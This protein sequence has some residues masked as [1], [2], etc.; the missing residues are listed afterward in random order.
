MAITNGSIIRM[1]SVWQ[2]NNSDE[3]ANVWH[4]GVSSVAS[5]VALLYDDIEEYLVYLYGTVAGFIVDDL[6]H[7][8]VEVFNQSAG[9]PEPW[10]G[11][12]GDLDGTDA[13]S[14]LPAGVAALVYAR[15]FVSRVIGKKYMPTASE[16]ELVNGQFSGAYQTALL[17][18]A[19]R[20]AGNFTASNGTV[21]TP[22][23]WRV[24][25]GS[26]V[27]IMSTHV[28]VNPAYQRRRKLGRG[29]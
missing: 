20:W 28:T 11:A 22:R 3:Q 10:I 26:D 9:T 1:A 5:T 15:T 18:L 7:N 14:P 12:I 24:S 6:T 23:I 19:T 16:N 21:F 29:A 4:A 2:Y 8:R 25:A 17:G 13:N 27:G